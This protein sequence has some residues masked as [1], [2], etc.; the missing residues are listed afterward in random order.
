MLKWMAMNNVFQRCLSFWSQKRQIRNGVPLIRRLQNSLH[1][2]GDK[3][4]DASNDDE[5]RKAYVVSSRSNF[6][7]GNVFVMISNELGY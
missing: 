5:K 3:N 1:K 2:G 7:I 6:G 4:G